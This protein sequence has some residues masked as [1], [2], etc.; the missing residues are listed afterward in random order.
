MSPPCWGRPTTLSAISH[1]SS[2]AVHQPLT[3]QQLLTEC[4]TVEEHKYAEVGPLLTVD[5]HIQEPSLVV[6]IVGACNGAHTGLLRALPLHQRLPVWR[7]HRHRDPAAESVLVELISSFFLRDT[8]NFGL[9]PW[10]ETT[11]EFNDQMV[12]AMD[13]INRFSVPLPPD[14]HLTL[15]A[16]SVI[17]AT[18]LLIHLVAVQLWQ[19]AW[20]GLLLLTMY[21]VP[22]DRARR[23]AGLAVHPAGARLH[24]ALS[25]VALAVSCPPYS[26]PCWKGSSTVVSPVATPAAGRR[27]PSRRPT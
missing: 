5:R 24:R 9:L 16:A 10:R 27:R 14:P 4:A 26:R 2:T 8:L 22:G 3:N 1:R 17:A 13:S 18:G 23:T 20:A 12:N 19:A 11:L 7:G 6:A 25:V 15:F 21:T